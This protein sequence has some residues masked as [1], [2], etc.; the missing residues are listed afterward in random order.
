YWYLRNTENYQL[1]ADNMNAKYL[2]PL[3]MPGPDLPQAFAER[4]GSF[5]QLFQ[6]VSTRA[7]NVLMLVEEGSCLRADD[8]G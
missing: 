3:H 4:V 5:D 6:D 7:D 8:Q 2:V 1:I